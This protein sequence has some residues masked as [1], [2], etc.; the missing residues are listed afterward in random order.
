MKKIRIGIAGAGNAGMMHLKSLTGGNFSEAEVVAICDKTGRLEALKSEIPSDVKVYAEYSAMLADKACDAVIITTPHFFHPEMAIAA[1]K[2]GCHVFCEKPAGV[3]TENVKE[4]NRA[5][6]ESGKIFSMHFNRRLEPV[7]IKL[8]EMIASGETG[9]VKRIS[10]TTT[11]WFRTD[12]YFASGTWRGTWKGEGGGL[13]LNQCIHNLDI[14]Q[15]LF[16]MPDKVR[17]SC[18]FGKFHDNMEV[19]DEVTAIFNYKNG[20]SGVF[21]ASTGESPGTNRLEIFCDNGKLIVENRQIKF[22][23]TEG[24]VDDFCRKTKTGFGE[25][26]SNLIEIEIDGKADLSKGMLKNFVEAVSGKAPLLVDGKEGLKS[27]E[28]ANAIILSSW[29]DKTVS[30]PVDDKL[31]RKELQK[32]ISSSTLKKNVEHQV[33][34]LKDSF[35]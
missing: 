26:K 11:D 6:V 25:P 22:Y 8:K 10:W 9:A 30:I 18:S 15:N 23:K 27:L 35:K 12:A 13:L 33:F 34:D 24:P 21:I 32:R 4:M 3:F 5:A 1:F 7:F 16:G 14:W 29:L 19:E 17:S 31:Y 20:T 28:L 2:A